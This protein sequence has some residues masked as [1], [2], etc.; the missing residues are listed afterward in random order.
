M[1]AVK[2]LSLFE[3]LK[4]QAPVIPVYYQR[5]VLADLIHDEDTPKELITHLCRDYTDKD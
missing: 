3:T 1:E 2:Q 4:V 5:M